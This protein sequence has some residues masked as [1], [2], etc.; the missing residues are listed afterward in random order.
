MYAMKTLCEWN[1]ARDEIA[2]TI[3][4]DRIGCHEPAALSL[5]RY[6]EWHLCVRCAGLSAFAHFRE[7][8]TLAALLYATKHAKLQ[9]SKGAP[10][11]RAGRG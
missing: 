8:S 9:T 2:W 3:G 11:R 1:P 4:E 7:R 10:H 6:G 5:G